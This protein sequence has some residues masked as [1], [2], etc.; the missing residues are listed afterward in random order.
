MAA[1]ALVVAAGAAAILL[2]LLVFLGFVKY[3]PR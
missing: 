1:D 2:L 3:K